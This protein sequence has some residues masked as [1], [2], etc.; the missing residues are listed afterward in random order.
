MFTYVYFKYINTHMCIYIYIFIYIHIH[1]Y[2]CMVFAVWFRFHGISK[3]LVYR[4]V[5]SAPVYTKESP[6]HRVPET[7]NPKPSTL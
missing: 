4:L 3:K 1:M 7:P 6:K 5:G 2:M